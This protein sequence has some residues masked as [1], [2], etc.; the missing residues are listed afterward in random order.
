MIILSKRKDWASLRDLVLH[1]KDPFPSSGKLDH[2]SSGSNSG[3]SRFSLHYSPSARNSL[4]HTNFA[5]KSVSVSATPN[6]SFAIGGER[7]ESSS[8]ETVDLDDV[9][10][11]VEIAKE[12]KIEIEKEVKMEKEA[13]IEEKE[14][15][16]K[17]EVAGS[18]CKEVFL[19]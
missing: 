11:K 9:I 2:S 4:Y 15:P 17:K 13:K 7:K 3:G 18:P 16:E 1:G 12:V 8:Y 5:K 14:E 10:T 19:L 6:P